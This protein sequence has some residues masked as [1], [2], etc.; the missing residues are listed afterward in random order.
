MGQ[1]NCII[2]ELVVIVA[3]KRFL[4]Y[5]PGAWLLRSHREGLIRHCCISSR[6][7]KLAFK[8]D[9]DKV[10]AEYITPLVV[11]SIFIVKYF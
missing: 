9:T 5:E 2:G 6:I 4:L 1:I 3:E 7:L 8:Y 11:F 10:F